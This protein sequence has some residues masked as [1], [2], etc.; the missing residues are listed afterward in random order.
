M[1]LISPEPKSGGEL[2]AWR[3]SRK[4]SQARV[5]E[6][7]GVSRATIGR[8]ERADARLSPKVQAL[9]LEPPGLAGPGGWQERTV[10]FPL[11]TTSEKAIRDL[12]HS[13]A[14]IADGW[15]HVLPHVALKGIADA[16]LHITAPYGQ[17]LNRLSPQFNSLARDYRPISDHLEAL[18]EQFAASFPDH[19]DFRFVNAFLSDRGWLLSGETPSGLVNRLAPL[20]RQGEGEAVDQA[21]RDHVGARLDEIVHR[22][23]EKCPLRAPILAAAAR[24]HAERAFEL[25]VPTLLSQAD[26]MALELIGGHF[27]RRTATPTRKSTTETGKALDEKLPDQQEIRADGYLAP[28][29]IAVFVGSSLGVHTQVRI[30]GRRADPAYGPLNRHGVLH[31]IDKDYATEDNSLRAF[32]LVE[33]ILVLETMLE[34]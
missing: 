24:A 14:A 7:L 9:L 3:L 28:L 31:G 17:M 23:S 29:L 16:V 21:M 11:S 30:E 20:V 10:S 19:E 4:F 5:A 25:T 22:A 32:L 18:L 33:Y 34:R 2:R 8:W 27:F 12:T 1:P 6:A 26:G 15:A 13:I